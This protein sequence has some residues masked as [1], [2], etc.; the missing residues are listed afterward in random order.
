MHDK[1]RRLL[2]CNLLKAFFLLIF[3]WL[4]GCAR[5]PAVGR[6]PAELQSGPTLRVA[7]GTSIAWHPDGERVA[8]AGEELRIWTPASGSV[9]QLARGPLTA[10]VWSPTGDR[11][12]VARPQ[13]AE[14]KLAVL[15][16]RGRIERETLVA[17]HVESLF[18][19][20]EQGVLAAATTL[21]TFS[22]GGDFIV[23]LYRWPGSEAPDKTVLHDVS[24]KPLTLRKWGDLL[25]RTPA[26]ALSALG[27]ELVFTRLHDPP[28][29]APYLKIMLHHLESGSER[30]V[31]SVALPFGHAVYA[32]KDD[33]ILFGDG[34]T[35]RT[36]DPWSG[37]A[38]EEYPSAGRQVS[39][40]PDGRYLLLDG[41]LYRDGKP[42]A[43]FSPDVA[44]CFSPRGGQLL[45]RRAGRL[46]LL[47]GLDQPASAPL[48][49]ALRRQLLELRRWRSVGLISPQ[50]YIEQLQRMDG[51]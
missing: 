15:D 26:P 1:F 48:P 42:F 51:R 4:G 8:V 46:Y 28:A 12:A 11:L 45:L 36:L 31:T 32:G 9:Q 14:T 2:Q 6:L 33:S 20:A 41:R 3:L 27:D 19:T 47:G 35:V 38:G 50:D 16:D 10:V 25:P 24:L 18:W 13:G 44:G 43:A 49:P 29:F 23:A 7:P 5:V 30:E 22:F 17:G 37:R 34:R 21:E 39:A 40:S